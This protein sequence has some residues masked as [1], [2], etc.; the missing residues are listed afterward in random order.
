[1]ADIGSVRIQAVMSKLRPQLDSLFADTPYKVSLTGHSLVLQSNDYLLGNLYESLLI[2]I[3]L[4]AL[5][6]MLLSGL[7]QSFYYRNYLV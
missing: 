1:M 6:G 3:I 5:V 2:A 7:S 4:I